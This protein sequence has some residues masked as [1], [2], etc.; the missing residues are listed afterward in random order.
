MNYTKGEW[1]I[2]EGDNCYIIGDERSYTICKVPF[3]K[4]AEANANLIAATPN[5]NQAL[6]E[7]DQWLIDHPDISDNPQLH[8]IHIH[9]RDALAKAEGK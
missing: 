7:I 5:Q 4:E 1:Q 6:T 3:Y 9:I 2:I 8:I